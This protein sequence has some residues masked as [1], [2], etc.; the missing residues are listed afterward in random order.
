MPA[1]L[2]PMSSQRRRRV[3]MRRCSVPFWRSTMSAMP[4]VMRLNRMKFTI[5]P[6]ELSTK[7]LGVWPAA[8]PASTTCVL[9][10]G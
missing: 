4:A 8:A 6:G 5:M 7:P 2:P 10:A 1:A 9:A 3:V